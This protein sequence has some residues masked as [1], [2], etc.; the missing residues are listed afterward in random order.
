MVFGWQEPRVEPAG[1]R[2]ERLDIREELGTRGNDQKRQMSK[3][4]QE[5]TS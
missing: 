3:K 2:E 1:E 4:E 5:S